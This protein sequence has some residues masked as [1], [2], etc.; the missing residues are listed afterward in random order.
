MMNELDHLTA[1]E[2]NSE[3]VK[4]KMKDFYKQTDLNDNSSESTTSDIVEEE[5]FEMMIFSDEKENEVK[6]SNDDFIINDD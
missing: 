4:K 3:N 6:D 1:A 5:K 2:V